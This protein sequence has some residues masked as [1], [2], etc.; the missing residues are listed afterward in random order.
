M[1]LVAIIC[2]IL[3]C[4]FNKKKKKNYHVK[5]V[6]RKLIFSHGGCNMMISRVMLSVFL[7]L[8]FRCKVTFTC[9]KCLDLVNLYLKDLMVKTC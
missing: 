1:K 3:P 7:I 8:T 9:K 6:P 4:V 2:I 5:L